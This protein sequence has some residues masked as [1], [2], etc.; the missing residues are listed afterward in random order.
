MNRHECDYW[1]FSKRIHQVV[2]A[3]ILIWQMDQ[4]ALLGQFGSDIQYFSHREDPPN[5]N[6]GGCLTRKINRNHSCSRSWWES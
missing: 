2:L 1:T 3:V 4:P 6:A 5:P